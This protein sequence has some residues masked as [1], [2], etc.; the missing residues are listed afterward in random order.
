VTV[1][2]AISLSGTVTEF[3]AAANTLTELIDPTTTVLGSAGVPVPLNLS[4]STLVADA[5]P[6]EGVLVQVGPVGV[7]QALSSNQLV[8]SDGPAQLVMDDVAFAYNPS[9]YPLGTCF[10]SV[11]GVLDT[12]PDG[13]FR[14]LPRTAFDLVTGT[15]CK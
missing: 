1:G 11:T 7:V 13:T 15:G 6:Y 10:A 9:S 14:L 2:R 5:E 3:G 12:A 4:L 8:L